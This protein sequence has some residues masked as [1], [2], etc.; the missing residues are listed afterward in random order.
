M[1][2]VKGIAFL[3]VFGP[4]R[5]F[6][7]R[8]SHSIGTFSYRIAARA[9]ATVVT[10]GDDG[11]DDEGVDGVQCM[12]KQIDKWQMEKTNDRV[13]SEELDTLN[14]GKKHEMQRCTA[15]TFTIFSLSNAL[16]G[17]FRISAPMAVSS[18]AFGA[19]L[20]TYTLLFA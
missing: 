11:G 9:V 19:V 17:S 10:M 14:G 6:V 15:I 1:Q 3:I 5:P 8:G 13:F 18:L 2:L 20:L 12:Q 16:F 7:I 4:D